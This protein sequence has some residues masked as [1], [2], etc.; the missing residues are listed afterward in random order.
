[1][2]LI[3]PLVARGELIGAIYLG[4]RL[5][6][7]DYGPDDRRILATLGAQAAPAICVAQLVRDQ[8]I[9]IQA[10]ERLEQ[11]LRVATLIQQQFLPRE[12]PRLSGWQVAAH[13]GP[14]R[15][16]GG[17]FYDF[18]PLPDGRIGIVVGDVTDKGVPAALIMARTQSILRGEAPRLMSPARVLERVN[19][20]LVPE[21][22]ARMFAT[23]LYL[24]LEPATGKV[25][26]ANAGHNVPYV[27][28]ATGVTELRAAGM[29][30]GLLPGM[31][32][33]EQEAILAPGE[34]LLLYSDGLVEAH[35]AA[36]AM[37]GF[38]RLR[39]L[40][41]TV[42][43]GNDL[44]DHLLGE[45]HGFVGR[46]WEQED[47]ITLVALARTGS[48][49]TDV[50][51]A[52]AGRGA[53]PARSTGTLPAPVGRRVLLTLSLPGAPGNEHR[54]MDEVARVVDALGISPARLERLGTAVSEAAMNA[55]EYGSRNDP[56]V[57]FD[58][59]ASVEG[60]DLIVRITD[61]G[62]G[63]P[64]TPDEEP[65]L[66]RKLAGDEQPRGWGLF[67]IRHMVDA[68]QV[69][70]TGAGR[71]VALTLHLEGGDDAAYPV[72]R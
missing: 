13:Y 46:G 55:I 53:D 63:G 42:G 45:L 20:I 23:C 36:G 39:G 61:R 60:A 6:D 38:A 67:L 65:D 37:F 24:V 22:P 56:A 47:D 11:E 68:V 30:L 50:V 35:D 1:M 15:A 19:E 62:P 17:D 51:T 18:I 32:Y 3:V 72:Q 69:E 44:L 2:R 21:M 7:Q 8:A 70:T 64:P 52:D 57:P 16:V 48:P 33:P 31:D 66:E 41:A 58:V 4:Q 71:T 29:P 59:V 12:L 5:S 26:F 25:T 34:T 49:G 9:E 27:R 54:A 28:T 14:A 10:R 43:A 40:V